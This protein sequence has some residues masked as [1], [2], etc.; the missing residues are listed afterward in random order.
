[1][2]A[3]RI[4][5]AILTVPSKT[6]A[7]LF[8]QS[9]KPSPSQPGTPTARST[10]CRNCLRSFPMPSRLAPL[11]LLMG[12]TEGTEGEGRLA[13][14][15][16]GSPAGRCKG[17]EALLVAVRS[18]SERSSLSASNCASREEVVLLSFGAKVCVEP[19]EVVRWKGGGASCGLVSCKSADE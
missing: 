15:A 11:I 8:N 19:E 9:G 3:P 5:F 16:P 12:G 1:M 6:P 13:R 4:E 2:P 17:E 18:E 10:L 14:G 7:P